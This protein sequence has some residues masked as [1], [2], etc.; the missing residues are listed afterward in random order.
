MLR[1]MGDMMRVSDKRRLVLGC[2]CGGKRREIGI[3]NEIEINSVN[4]KWLRD[5]SKRKG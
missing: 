3:E 5:D 4:L 1:V 2:E